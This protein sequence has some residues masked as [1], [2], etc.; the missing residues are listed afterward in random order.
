MGQTVTRLLIESK[1]EPVV[2][3]LNLETVHHMRNQG[4]Y[5]IYGDASQA[6]TLSKAGVRNAMSLILSAAGMPGSQ[7]VIRLAKEANSHIQVFARS[8]HLREAAALR[9][10]GADVVFSGEGEVAL[11]MTEFMLRQI[12]ATPEQID[13]ER[14]RL[15]RVLLGG[16]A[17]ESSTATLVP[18]DA[19]HETKKA[20]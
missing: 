4:I 9:Q 8:V 12:G 3:E 14:D 18:T 6:E 20:T 10:A 13:R 5:A 7:E 17:D 15:R 16:P 1:I 2:I 19:D 11:A